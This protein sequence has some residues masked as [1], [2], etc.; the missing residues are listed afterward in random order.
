MFDWTRKPAT[1]AEGVVDNQGDPMFVSDFSQFWNWCDV[2]TRIADTLNIDSLGLLV[3]GFLYV[4]RRITFDEL[5]SDSE[6][7]QVD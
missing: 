4:R 6:V 5:D 3:D 2:V 7:L 1:N